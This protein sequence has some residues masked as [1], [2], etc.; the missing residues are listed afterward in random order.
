MRRMT[1][2]VEGATS[3]PATKVRVE[4]APGDIVSAGLAKLT[5]SCTTATFTEEYYE[6]SVNRTDGDYI[7]EFSEDILSAGESSDFL[8]IGYTDDGGIGIVG[9]AYVTPGGESCCFFLILN[10]LGD[11]GNLGVRMGFVFQITSAS[12]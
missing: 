12:G 2:V 6:G 9:A 8:T 3:G 5:G 1:R 10:W 7:F 11:A 4:A